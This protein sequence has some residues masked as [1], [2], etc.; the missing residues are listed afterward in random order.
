VPSPARASI[1]DE[2]AS[3]STLPPPVPDDVN[4]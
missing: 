1:I 2:W 4:F 3:V